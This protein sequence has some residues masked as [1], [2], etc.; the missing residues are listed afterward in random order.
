MAYNIYQLLIY[1][2]S[3]DHPRFIMNRQYPWHLS[4]LLRKSH[5]APFKWT[6]AWHEC[7]FCWGGKGTE[8]RYVLPRTCTI[9][10]SEMHI[11]M[12]KRT[13]A[14]AQHEDFYVFVQAVLNILSGK[15]VH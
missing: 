8:F 10:S 6:D 4:L 1:S 15:L 9:Q 3:N 5:G 14:E 12:L 7:F 2:M 11:K 13:N